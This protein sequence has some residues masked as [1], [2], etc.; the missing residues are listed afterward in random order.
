MKGT[1]KETKNLLSF[2]EG[3]VEDGSEEIHELEHKHFECQVVFIFCLRPMHFCNKAKKYNR[4]LS[5]NEIKRYYCF[6]EQSIKS[7]Y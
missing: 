7:P 1:F 4:T 2:E 6:K 5:F 3:D